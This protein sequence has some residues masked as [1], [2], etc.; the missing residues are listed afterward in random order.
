MTQIFLQIL[1]ER[2]SSVLK[3][4]IVLLNTGPVYGGDIN[5]AHVLTTAQGKYFLKTNKHAA[6]DMFEKEF[7]GL[8]LLKHADCITVPEPI[9]YGE[10]GGLFF[11]VM[12]Y[13]NKGFPA[14]DFWT[15]FANGLASLHKLTQPK[16]GLHEN[17][18]IGSLPQQNDYIDSWAEFYKM[19]RIMP[20]MQKVFDE[21]KC[22]REDMLL[23][24]RLCSK[25]DTLFP[26]EAPALLHG[27]LW[28]GNF[29]VNQKGLPAIYDPA[30]YYGHREMDLGMTLL[31]G[32]FDQKLYL[33]YNEIFPLEKGWRQRV[34]LCQLYPLLVHVVL[35]GGHYWHSAMNI[36]KK[37]SA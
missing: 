30:I 28:S 4:E 20:L 17:N 16:F 34:D 22:G 33:H 23:A 31:F 1:V 21:H 18:Y 10:A 15:S 8:T 35:F 29:T 26:E 25:L 24:E 2:L 27:D 14:A 12:E 3:K 7:N 6:G 13:I 9:L 32:G 36:I 5:S 19:Q 11:I 37:Y